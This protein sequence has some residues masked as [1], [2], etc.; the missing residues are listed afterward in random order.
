MTRLPVLSL[1]GA[2][3]LAATLLFGTLLIG[4]LLIG[5]PGAAMAQGAPQ[6]SSQAAT[7]AT[8]QLYPGQ[9]AMERALD[10]RSS[11][12]NLRRWM[13]D[14]T[15]EVHHAGSPGSRKN[16]EY[17]A[18][19]FR[20]WGY[21]VEIEVYHVLLPTPKERVVELVHPE[22][23]RL[24]LEEPAI[25]EDASSQLRDGMLPPYNAYSA[26]GDVEA[27]LVYVNQGLPAD[28][29]ELRRRGISVEGKIVIAR[30]GGSWRGIKPKVAAEN[31][32]IATI[33]YSDP[34]DD[35]YFRGDVYPEGPWRMG[36]GVQRGSVSDMPTFPGDPL[37]PFVGA[38]EDAERLAIEDAP[39]IMKIPVL[40]ISY[41]EALPL[42]AA[43]EGPVA[44]ARFR[45]ALP[46]T[47]HLG[48][49][50]ARVHMKLAFNW[51]IV[52]AYNVIA[53]L[54][55][56]EFPDEWVMRGN[57]RDAWAFG[58]NDPISGTV[59]MMEE[60]RILGELAREGH[61]PRRTIVFASWDAEEPGLLGSTEW[62][63]HHADEL[64]EKL[65]TYIN[66]D[67]TGRGYLGMGG[68]HSLEA[69]INDIARDVQ[70][71][72]A[73]GASLL[74]RIRA[75][76][77]AQQGL[78]HGGA[79]GPTADIPIAPLGSGS[80]Y[81]PFLQHL[82]ISVLNLSFGGEGGGGSY[83]SAY[84][85]FEHYTRFIDPEFVYGA[86]LPKVTGRATLRLAM[87][88]VLPFHFA[89]LVDRI[90]TYLGEIESMA[91]A[92]REETARQ[93]QLIESGAYALSNDPLDPLLAPE[94]EDEVPYFPFAHIRNA[95]TELR[96]AAAAADKAAREA[97]AEAVNKAA[98]QAA[99]QAEAAGAADQK[100]ALRRINQALFTVE[101]AMTDMEG[102]PRRPWFRHQI[103]APGFYTGYGV[104]TL[105][106]VR[107]AIEERK[108]Q[109]A[110]DE[111]EDL[112]ATLQRMA[113]A[114]ESV[115]DARP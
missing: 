51:D 82:G 61:R 42:L 36:M 48:P 59:A 24:T 92:M 109:E 28:Y 11:A 52:P 80:D 25:E 66:T 103:Y 2:T 30:Y 4:A 16:A 104:K 77:A 27:E 38:T 45:G 1:A 54:E 74:D 71:P 76:N 40:P 97:T 85:T 106:G 39:T 101:R 75:R 67:G 93:N 108:W 3:R 53:R 47:Y 9:D 49:G 20:E 100:A 22:R 60:A 21:D 64:R 111:I 84:D 37:T 32:A 14:L 10:E 99:S 70:D 95:I 17:V 12:E 91:D 56:S 79:A 110:H 88:D 34:R 46:I 58:A 7:A 18:K 5:A 89:P 19:Q 73:G 98:S 114:L 8:Q 57:H 35:G 62:A 13:R 29:E 41:D 113:R 44:P 68:S 43:L 87:M 78:E 15:R 69:M 102:L 65:V 55:G 90:E 81:T 94:P 83:H 86:T 23:V 26:D 63:E 50:P 72:R 33:M 96:V 112:A 31:G 6:Q 107:E 115:V 105:P